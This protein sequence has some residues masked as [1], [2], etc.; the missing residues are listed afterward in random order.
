MLY[1]G[2]R[3]GRS[4]PQLVAGIKRDSLTMLQAGRHTADTPTYVPFLFFFFQNIL[5]RKKIFFFLFKERKN[6]T[7]WIHMV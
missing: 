6:Q 2:P 4:K 3:R 5:V 7:E 1:T